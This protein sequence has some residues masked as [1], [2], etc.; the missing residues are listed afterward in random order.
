MSFVIF[1]CSFAGDI[2][3][4]NIGSILNFDEKARNLWYQTCQNDARLA[5]LGISLCS[6][7][8]ASPKGAG[9]ESPAYR[10]LREHNSQNTNIQK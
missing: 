8:P 1:S 3:V 9:E 7:F 5:I 10:C 4:Y 6:K 2:D